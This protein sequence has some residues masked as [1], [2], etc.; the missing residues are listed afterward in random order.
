MAVSLDLGIKALAE[1]IAGRINTLKAAIGDTTA[2]QTTVKTSLVAAINE[3]KLASASAAGINDSSTATTSSWSSSKINTAINAAV[4]ALV[5]GAP[6][7]LDQ[8]NELASAIGNDANFATTIATALSN[9]LRVDIDQT[10]TAAQKLQGGKNLGVGDVTRDF[11]AD[12]N[13]AL[14]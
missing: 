4:T 14:T 11:V 8:I 7:T 3:V 12:F 5:N 2:L 6:G 13:A 9:R 1:A 10:L